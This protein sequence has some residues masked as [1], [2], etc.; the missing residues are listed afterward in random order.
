V[1]DGVRET[2]YFFGFPGTGDVLQLT[3]VHDGRTYDLGTGFNHIAV[4]VD[5]LDATLAKLKDQ[6]REPEQPPFQV[7]EGDPFICFVRDPDGYRVELF[8]PAP[9]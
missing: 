2:H 3:A 6:G 9:Q 1:R 5:D 7:R 4:R 8:G